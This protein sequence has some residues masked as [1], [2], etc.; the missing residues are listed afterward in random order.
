[1]LP[2]ARCPLTPCSLAAQIDVATSQASE[3]KAEANQLRADVARLSAESLN[4]QL[5]KQVGSLHLEF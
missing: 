3:Y 2:C 5:A 4:M 1:M